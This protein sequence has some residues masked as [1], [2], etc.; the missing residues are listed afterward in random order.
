MLN[1]AV[2]AKTKIALRY[3]PS[4]TN[5]PPITDE[6]MDGNLAKDVS[7]KK[8]MNLIGVKAKKYIKR[9]LGVPGIK[10]RRNAVFFN[11]FLV[12]INRKDLS[13][14]SETRSLEKL[15]PNFLIRK[16]INPDAKKIPE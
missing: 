5:F 14:S 16:K 12:L 10:K 11:L 1:N 6:N 2:M 15:F 8:S 13:F 9:S 4:P 7:I 3:S